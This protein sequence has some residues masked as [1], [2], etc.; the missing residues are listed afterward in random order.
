MADNTADSLVIKVGL[1]IDKSEYI[2]LKK[3][4]KDNKKNSLNLKVNPENLSGIKPDNT[5]NTE[6][7][8]KEI[9]EQEK[10]QN[11]ILDNKS[12]KLSRNEENN[13]ESGTSVTGVLGAIIG[14]VT[15]AYVA[16]NQLQKKYTE[17][18]SREMNLASL[19]YQT[20]QTV[21]KLAKLNYQANN[22]G[23]TLA[24]VAN[25][26]ANFSDD[27]FDGSNERKS[28]MLAQLG[29]NPFDL[30]QNAKG[31]ED[32]AKLQQY[33][34]KTITNSAKDRG[35]STFSATNLASKYSGISAQD[36][37]GYSKLF[38]KETVKNANEISEAR[39]PI[40]NR[41]EVMKNF[42]DLNLQLQKSSAG[43]DK[44]LSTSDIAKKISIGVAE[45]EAGTV[46]LVNATINF[47]QNG[48]GGVVKNA[49]DS[50]LD[51]IPNDERSGMMPRVSGSAQVK[52][53]N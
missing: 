35:F 2:D 36:A 27:L 11:N 23:L 7:V 37:F 8:L 25:S 46:K 9:L 24:Q 28:M 17:K 41:D 3:E 49:W 40:G 13:N 26:A 33:I 48:I 10:K 39:G 30:A 45:I 19:S 6:K 47:A 34:Q 43:I 50:F 15:A 1:D 38:N 12:Q 32:I 52:A 5:S 44:M 42:Q 21:D 31:P 20:G 53:G 29:I 18:L 51:N 16:A 14:V 4:L 22:V